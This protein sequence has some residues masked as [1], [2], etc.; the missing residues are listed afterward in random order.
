MTTDVTMSETVAGPRVESPSPRVQALELGVFLFLIMP[1]LVL[2]QFISQQGS[3]SF[4]PLAVLEIL[5]DLALVSLIAFFLWR[6]G[7]SLGGFHYRRAAVRA[8]LHG[9]GRP[10]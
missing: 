7:E 3:I 9:N 2:S 4:V 1:S 8:D 5:R 10:G 6:N